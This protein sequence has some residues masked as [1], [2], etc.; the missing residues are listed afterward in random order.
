MNTL[1]NGF[2]DNKTGLKY[3]IA[4]FFLCLLSVKLYEVLQTKVE[5]RILKFNILILGFVILTTV[6]MDNL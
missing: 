2:D 1:L 4:R 5:I 3:I 6:N